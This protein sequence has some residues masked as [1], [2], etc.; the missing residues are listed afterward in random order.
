[1]LMEPTTTTVARG[2]VEA[3]DRLEEEEEGMGG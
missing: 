2:D 3:A 1:M